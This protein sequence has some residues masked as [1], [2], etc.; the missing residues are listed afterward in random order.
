MEGRRSLR[1]DGSWG[2]TKRQRLK[3]LLEGGPVWQEGRPRF[4][5]GTEGLAEKAKEKCGLRPGGMQVRGPLADPATDTGCEE[6]SY[7]GL[8]REVATPKG[9]QDHGGGAWEPLGDMAMQGP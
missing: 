1:G 2:H 8:Q 6:W 7:R 4:L 9:L 3:E 5:R